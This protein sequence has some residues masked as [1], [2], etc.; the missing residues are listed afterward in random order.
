LRFHIVH[1]FNAQQSDDA[2][3]AWTGPPVSGWSAFPEGM[4]THSH[5]SQRG[6]LS[7][8]PDSWSRSVRLHRSL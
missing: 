8:T 1:L 6:S 3:A 7:L 2:P 4:E 5:H